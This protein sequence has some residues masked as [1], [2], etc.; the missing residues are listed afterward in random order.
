MSRTD[1]NAAIERIKEKV[2][3]SKV[4]GID[5][6]LRKK[7]REF[8]GHCPFHLEKTA[9]FFVNDDKGTFY[10]FGCGASG[11]LIEYLIK[12]HRITF[13]QALERLAEMAGVKLPEK[14]NY[15]NGFESHQKILQKAV[16][17][18]KGALLTNRVA[19]EY[20]E[21]RNID[22]QMIDLFSIGYAGEKY[23]MQLLEYLRKTGLAE[24]DIFS[25]GLF[26][27]KERGIVERFR[28]RLMFP[29]FNRNGWPIAFGGRG[30]SNG[31]VPKY[32]NSPESEKIGRAHV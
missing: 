5:V 8:V 14:T 24:Q 11:D 31:A 19:M 28:D 27:E 10:C 4:V 2:P 22:Q 17:F 6:V 20:C 26:V 13:I 1:L 15:K 21:R 16:E 30:L 18:F 9:S 3:L 12:K 29:V 7:G 32:L 23:L 25:S